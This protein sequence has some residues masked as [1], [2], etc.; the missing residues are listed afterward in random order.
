MAV[1]SGSIAGGLALLKLAKALKGIKLLGA[2]GKSAAGLLAKKKAAG[3]T[4][5]AAKRLQQKLEQRCPS[6]WWKFGSILGN[7]YTRA[8]YQGWGDVAMS[9]VPDLVY[10]GITFATQPGD[11]VDKSIAAGTQ[12]ALGGIELVHCEQEQ[13]LVV[14]S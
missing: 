11:I 3:A 4:S 8:G 6:L 1:V 5:A 7:A 14:W 2:A 12:V 10:G 9:T 13:V